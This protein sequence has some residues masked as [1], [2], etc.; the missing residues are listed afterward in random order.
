MRKKIE[1]TAIRCLKDGLFIERAITALKSFGR[2]E[3]TKP[4]RDFLL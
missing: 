4:I 3:F 2:S 1:I